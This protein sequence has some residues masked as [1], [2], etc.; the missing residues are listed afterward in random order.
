MAF[1]S[2]DHD[3]VPGLCGSMVETRRYQIPIAGSVMCNVS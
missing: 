3:F 2:E 1:K